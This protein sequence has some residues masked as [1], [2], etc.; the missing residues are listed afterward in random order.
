MR[1]F[2][3]VAHVIDLDWMREAYRRTRKDGVAG[4]DGRSADDFAANLE[5][6]LHNLAEKLRA[7][8]YRPPPVR[9]AHIP[10][11]NGKRRPLGIP[12][13]ADRIHDRTGMLREVGDIDM[14]RLTSPGDGA[15]QPPTPARIQ[16]ATT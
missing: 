7:G 8:S 2:L 16:D 1:V 5:K 15:T 10:K 14:P 12:V 3:S 6:N 11:A 4:V 13:I 9:R